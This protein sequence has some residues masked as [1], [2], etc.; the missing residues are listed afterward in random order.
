MKMFDRKNKNY[1]NY[2]FIR[3]FVHSIDSAPTYYYEL[4]EI[5]YENDGKI[6]AW[7][8]QPVS[9][10]IS[11]KKDLKIFLKQIKRATKSTVLQFNDNNI[12]VETNE[13]MLNN[14]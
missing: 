3:K 9:L 12:L 11:D 6:I 13:Y 4:Y 10:E 7:S 1:W 8:E 5:Y 14:T 2:R